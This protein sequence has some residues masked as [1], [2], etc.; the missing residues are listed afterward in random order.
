VA[1]AHIPRTTSTSFS[2]DEGA[3]VGIDLD[4]PVSEDYEAGNASRFTGRIRNV[5]VE[6]K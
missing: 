2:G 4:T 1:A 6:I 3:D 5:T